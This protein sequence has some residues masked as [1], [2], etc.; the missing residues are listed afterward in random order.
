MGAEK[1]GRLG[2]ELFGVREYRAVLSMC[3]PAVAQ[4]RHHPDPQGYQRRSGRQ[5]GR[6]GGGGAVIP[7]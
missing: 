3:I 5:G 6:R 2:R 4:E 1:E 7:R